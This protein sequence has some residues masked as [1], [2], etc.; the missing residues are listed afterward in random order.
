MTTTD[1]WTRVL[2]LKEPWFVKEIRMDF[3][4][5]VMEIEVC[6]KKTIWAEAGQ[7]LHI[8]DYEDRSWRHLDMMQ[9]TTRIVSRVPRLKYPD[10][11]TRMVDVP[12]AEPL[13]RWSK[14]F[15][16]FA[17]TVLLACRNTE[18]GRKFLR[19]DWESCQ[20]IMDRAVA[21]G[22]S[23]RDLDDIDYVGIDEKSF[24]RGQSFVTVLSDLNNARVVEVTPDRTEQSAARAFAALGPKQDG[25]KA[26]AMDMAAAYMKATKERLP[27]ADIVHDKFHLS[28]MLNDA[29]D[30][31]RRGENKVLLAE[32]DNL[33]T[34]TRQMWL[35][36]EHNL[37]EEDR[38]IFQELRASNLKTARAYYYKTLFQDIWRKRGLCAAKKHFEMWYRGAIRCRRRPIK[39]VAR[40][41][42]IHLDGILNYFI[43]RITNALAEALN[44]RI[45]EIKANAR[46]FR[47]FDN[48]RTRILFFCGKLDMILKPS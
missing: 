42:K 14:L 9:F 2:E 46:G 37:R 16:N 8:H 45:Q 32:G 44:S 29:V 26:V 3:N 18:Q 35:F 5:K 11:T 24:R 27:Q 41:F 10:G 22:I 4:E 20:A 36:N 47:S 23:R 31:V 43:H 38:E 39:E 15:E 30:K 28:Q 17:V 34:G 7:R 48:Y 6:C 19:L 1:F 21:R 25:I 40:S 33:L 12:W 13:S